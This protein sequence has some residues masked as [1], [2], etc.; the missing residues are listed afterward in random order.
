MDEQERRRAMA[1]LVAGLGPL[2]VARV[3]G[4]HKETARA[5]Q[6]GRNGSGDATY[7]ALHAEV[8]AG[9]DAFVAVWLDD[10]TQRRVVEATTRNQRER[11]ERYV[12]L[13]LSQPHPIR[14]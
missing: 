6:S 8:A 11:W 4:I 2:A 7:Q 14:Q 9:R 10:A 5:M 12:E 1:C 3:F 13:V